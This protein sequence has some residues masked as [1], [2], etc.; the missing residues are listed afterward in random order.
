MTKSKQLRDT[1]DLI[2]YYSEHAI[3]MIQDFERQHPE[4]KEKIAKAFNMAARHV[5][6]L[7]ENMH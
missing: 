1:I 2:D 3:K 6:K 5:I 4:Q 7:A